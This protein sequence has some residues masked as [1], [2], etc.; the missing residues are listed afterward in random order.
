MPRYAWERRSTTDQPARSNLSMMWS[1]ESLYFLEVNTRLQVEHPVTEEVSGVDLVEWMIRPAA[2][3]FALPP[4]SRVDGARPRHPGAPL[5]GKSS[6]RIFDPRP[7]SS[8]NC[9]SLPTRALK[10]GLKQGYGVSPFYDPLLGKSLRMVE[11]ALPRCRDWRTRSIKPAYGASRLT[12][13]ISSRSC[14]CEA[15][16]YGVAHHA[17]AWGFHLPAPQRRGVRARRAIEPAG[18]PGT[19]GIL[20]CRHS[21]ERSDGRALALRLVNQILGNHEGAAVLECTAGGAEL[22]VRQR[23]RDCAGRRD[24]GGDAR[25][26]A[27]SVLGAR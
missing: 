18:L 14:S 23:Q 12:L 6:N 26:R 17:R 1:A 11:I 16:G 8:P 4:P 5:R 27:R 25:W 10:A 15:F 20:G 24:D 9:L 19:V 13:A 21:A 3:E 22:A 7:A 2:G